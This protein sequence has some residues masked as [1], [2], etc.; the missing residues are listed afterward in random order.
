MIGLYNKKDSI[1][2]VGGLVIFHVLIC[3]LCLFWINKFAIQ[4]YNPSVY[5]LL[6]M[7]ISITVICDM[8][9]YRI[10]GFRRFLVKCRITNQGIHCTLL[11]LKKWEIKWNEICIF[12][13]L[14]Y[15]N[16]NDRGVFFLST[17]SGEKYNREKCA[18]VNA[19]RIV[20]EANPQIWKAVSEYMPDN[21]KY[22]LQKAMQERCN[23]FYKNK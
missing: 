4:D 7:F 16:T 18:E 14:G 19:K 23:T 2:V 17:D 6:L 10:Q 22:K 3:L 1:I 12:G 13:T 11:G 21:I 9:L 8:S 15:S 5:L 20:F